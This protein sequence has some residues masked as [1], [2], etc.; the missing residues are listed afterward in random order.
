MNLPSIVD[1][2]FI[3]AFYKYLI[4]ELDISTLSH[5][6]LIRAYEDLNKA[7]GYFQFDD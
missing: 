7:P 2:M 6:I 5:I 4:G 1:Q 3:I